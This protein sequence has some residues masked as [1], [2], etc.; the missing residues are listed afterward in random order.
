MAKM[1]ELASIPGTLAVSILVSLLIGRMVLELLFRVISLAPRVAV[2][3]SATGLTA[4][5]DNK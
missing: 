4:A 3:R 5:L 2:S 1:I